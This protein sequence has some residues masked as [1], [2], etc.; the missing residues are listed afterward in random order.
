MIKV[1]EYDV[2]RHYR[3]ALG[4]LLVYDVTKESTFQ[5]LKSWLDSLKQNAEHDIVIMLVGNKTDLIQ[6]Y[7]EEAREVPT[8]A[9][10]YFA[11]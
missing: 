5:N 9:A 8:E 4:A 3:K 1:D 10:K 7:G 6:M 2:Y 11:R